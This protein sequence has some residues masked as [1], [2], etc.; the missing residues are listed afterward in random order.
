[1]TGSSGKTAM[2]QHEDDIIRAVDFLYGKTTEGAL[3]ILDAPGSI[4]K[5]VSMTS[6]RS[7]YCVKGSSAFASRGK[8]TNSEDTYLCMIPQASDDVPI[9]FCSCRSFM[10]RNR[11]LT[12]ESSCLCKHLLALR[13]MPV[14]QVQPVLIE[15]A[16]DDEFANL[17]MQRIP[18]E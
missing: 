6:Q 3:A 4:S 15:T 16:S 1:M 17:L 5:V 7:I 9:Y 13:L 11:H 18:S 12:N 8:G 14:L 2:Q 10:E